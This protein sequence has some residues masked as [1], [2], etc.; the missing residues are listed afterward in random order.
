MDD[1]RYSF[2]GT[3][4]HLPCDIIRILW[5]IQ[6]LGLAEGGHEEEELRQA[7]HL[8]QM[9]KL[10]KE[11]LNF[12]KRELENFK[13]VKKRY[14]D[15]LKKLPKLKAHPQHKPVKLRITMKSLE[16]KKSRKREQKQ[17][18]KKELYC[19]C[20]DVSYGPMIACDNKFCPNEWF[21]YSCVGLI[22]APRP[23]EKWFCSTQCKNMSS[24]G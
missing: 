5:T 23:S 18:E 1:V 24:T 17:Q 19:I 9:I 12:E 7:R 21:H 13:N 14:D 11:R 8:L 6:S 20:R 15:Y 22:K 3:L 16:A 2:L 10:E 4:D